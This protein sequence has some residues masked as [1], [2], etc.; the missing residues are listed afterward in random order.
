MEC[1]ACRSPRIVRRGM[2][3][4]DGQDDVVEHI[5][6]IEM[7]TGTVAGTEGIAACQEDSSHGERHERTAALPP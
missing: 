3:A 7:E 6:G 1:E 2:G 4:V 5:D